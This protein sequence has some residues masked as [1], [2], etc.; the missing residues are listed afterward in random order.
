MRVLQLKNKS[1]VHPNFH[2]LVQDI[3]WFGL[4][5]PATTRF[6]SVYAVRVGAGPEELS[7]LTSLPAIL[8]LLAATMSRWWMKRYP[9]TIQALFWPSFGF[10]LTFLLPALTPFFPPEW[11]PAW[12]IVSL[13]LPALPQGIASVLFLVMMREAVDDRE[14][15]PLLSRR[16]LALNITVGLSGLMLGVWLDMVP[17]PFNYQAMFLLAFVL[18]LVSLWHVMQIRV[19]PL[20][21]LPRLTEAPVSG[22]NPWRTPAF[23]QVGFIAGIMHLAFFSV[24]PLT[25]LYLVVNMGAT[26]G[27]MAIFALFELSA[28]ALASTITGR[29]IERIGARNV[30]ALGMLGTAAGA[31]VIAFAPH[32]Y[33]TLPAAAFLGGAWTA[34]GIGLFA[35]FTESTPQEDKTPFTTAYLQVV[36]LA[37]FLAPMV[38]MLLSN[39]GINLV[40]IILF[41]AVL[42][43]IAAL[44]I[45]PRI[46]AVRRYSHRLAS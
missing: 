39:T 23:L 35:Y 41:G 45:Q 26:E 34:A 5:L 24:L 40:A 8:I 42:R 1:A 7:W 19:Q 31:A 12:L 6:L 2:H 15:T 3:V 32:L 36:Y 44:L 33:W 29:V 27:F 21:V 18:A 37:V 4:A 10:R 17:F 20:V 14:V 43:G 25:P 46:F 38:G 28:G 16:S 11:Q 30:I 13:A 22:R 9:S